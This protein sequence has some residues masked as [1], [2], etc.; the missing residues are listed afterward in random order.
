MKRALSN[1]PTDAEL[2]ILQTI[3][4]HGPM[5]VRQL[6]KEVGRERRSQTLHSLM[7]TMKSKGLVQRSGELRP[8]TYEAALTPDDIQQH[9][10]GRLVRF[11]GGSAKN[12]IM[13]VLSS[14]AATAEERDEVRRFLARQKKQSGN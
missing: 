8:Y 7:R 2:E 6:M 14:P 5:T 13:R 12:L 10:I 11:F 3:W 4:H 9:M 1:S